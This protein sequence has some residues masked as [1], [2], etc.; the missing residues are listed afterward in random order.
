M[1]SGGD[2]VNRKAVERK[3]IRWGFTEYWQIWVVALFFCLAF[4]LVSAVVL[5]FGPYAYVPGGL[6]FIAIGVIHSFRLRNNR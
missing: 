3:S 6:V 5:H 4:I 1:G 2:R